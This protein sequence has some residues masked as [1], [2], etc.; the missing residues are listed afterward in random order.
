MFS[1]ATVFGLSDE[2]RGE[3]LAMPPGPLADWVLML[4]S[5]INHNIMLGNMNGEVNGQSSGGH[6][7]EG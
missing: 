5:M 2:Y 6:R 7:E 4:K 3:A 1:S